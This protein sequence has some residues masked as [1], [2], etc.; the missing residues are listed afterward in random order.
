MYIVVLFIHLF[1]NLFF[2]CTFI[3]F[4]EF[5]LQFLF[6][7]LR[8]IVCIACSSRRCV[9]FSRWISLFHACSYFMTTE[10]CLNFSCCLFYCHTHTH[11][12]ICCRLQCTRTAMSEWL[13]KKKK[14]KRRR[15]KNGEKWIKSDKKSISTFS[16][17]LLC[18]LYTQLTTWYWFLS[19]C[20]KHIDRA[21]QF[22]ILDRSITARMYMSFYVIVMFDSRAKW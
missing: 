3:V 15:K 18:T 22:H 20:Y 6:R 10:N 14:R 13:K 8:F 4:P 2:V 7:L 5:S 16:L 9:A 11:T 19:I 1:I 21:Y 17:F 12:R